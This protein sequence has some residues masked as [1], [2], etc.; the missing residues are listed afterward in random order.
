MKTFTK[1]A[2]IGATALSLLAGA[3]AA[4]AQPYRGGYMPVEQRLDRLNDRIDRGIQSGQLDRRE[5]MRLRNDARDLRRLSFRYSRD[6]L[7]GWERADLDRRFDRLSARIN[8][9][10]HDAQY[11]YGYGPGSRR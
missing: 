9:D 3:G 4:S 5:A 1:T 7:S 6:G 11:G 8:W 2:L 10:R